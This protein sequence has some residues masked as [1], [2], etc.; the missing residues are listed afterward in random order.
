MDNDGRISFHGDTSLFQLPSA[1]PRPQSEH[2]P[3][4]RL[5]FSGPEGR[6]KLINNAWRQRQFEKLA[7]IP[8]SDFVDGTMAVT[9]ATA[10][11]ANRNRSSIC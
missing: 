9:G 1:S 11:T 2:D 3:N 10:L 7:Q 8:V 4:T 6:E 5:G